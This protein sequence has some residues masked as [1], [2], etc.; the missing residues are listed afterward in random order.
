MIR[1]KHSIT[2]TIENNV[3]DFIYVGELEMHTVVTYQCATY[4]V[5]PGPLLIVLYLALTAKTYET[6]AVSNF[7]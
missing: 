4:S 7:C 5:W 1:P 3:I 2:A 6:P